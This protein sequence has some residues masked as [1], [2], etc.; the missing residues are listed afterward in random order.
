MR[1]PGR[2]AKAAP[3]DGPKASG[4]IV[5]Q[6][7]DRAARL[8]PPAFEKPAVPDMDWTLRKESKKK[9]VEIS[10]ELQKVHNNATKLA[11]KGFDIGLKQATIVMPMGIG[12]GIVGSRILADRWKGHAQQPLAFRSVVLMP[13]RTLVDAE[14]CYRKCAGDGLTVL[15]IEDGKAGV[16]NIAS[17]L[18]TRAGLVVLGTYS[19]ADF[20]IAAFRRTRTYILDYLVF[21]MAQTAVG[22]TTVSGA[23]EL[24]WVKRY[25]IKVLHSIFLTPRSLEPDPVQGLDAATIEVPGLPSYTVVDERPSVFGPEVF[26]LSI[27]ESQ[28]KGITV[29]VQMI[30][31]ESASNIGHEL[32]DIH[33]Q[34]GVQLVQ[35]V[36]PLP[37]ESAQLI[38]EELMRTTQTSCCIATS[39]RSACEADALLVTA[40][41]DMAQDLN[42]LAMRVPGKDSAY[43]LIPRRKDLVTAAWK[44]LGEYDNRIQ[45]ALREAAHTY[46]FLGRNLQWDDLPQYLYTLIANYGSNLDSFQDVLPKMV[47][48]AI[49]TVVDEWEIWYGRLEAYR[50]TNTDSA[51]PIDATIHGYAL[52]RWVSIQFLEWRSGYLPEDKCQRLLDSGVSLEKENDRTFLEGVRVFENY[53]QEQ[54]GDPYVPSGY[55]TESGFALG[56]W[57]VSQRAAWKRGELSAEQQHLLYAIGFP[58]AAHPDDDETRKVTLHIDGILRVAHS[59]DLYFREKQF[60]K[61]VQQNHPSFC[62]KPY[63]NAVTH[64]LAAYREWFLFPPAPS[65]E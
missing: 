65:L 2:E 6:I 17:A 15:R 43:L 25:R 45:T 10:L 37:V 39:D 55:W 11:L 41:H 12:D 60:R 49:E 7:E 13:E 56:T 26:S 34:L 40:P 64:F 48:V 54:N 44:T 24:D 16:D 61:L 42:S 8:T 52:G 19:D 58:P 22:R 36:P 28:Q 31:L 63:A 30:F 1:Q 46:G 20:I 5:S 57:A 62:K 4:N 35:P 18:R 59:K 29:P 23:L 47:S 9:P 32:V 51:I 53:L 33:R 21:E 27:T 38:N 3:E 14:M 50:L